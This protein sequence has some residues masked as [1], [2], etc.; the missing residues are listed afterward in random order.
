[1]ED[2]ENMPAAYRQLIYGNHKTDAAGNLLY[3]DAE[4]HE[5]TD[6]GTEDAPHD[7]VYDGAGN[8]ELMQ[9]YSN[10]LTEL[11]G[12]NLWS[13]LNWFSSLSHG[14]GLFSIQKV[15]ISGIVWQDDNANGIQEAGES[16]RFAKVPV[17]LKRYW[18]GTNEEGEGWHLDETFDAHTVTDGNGYWIFDNLQVAGKRVVNGVEETVLYGFQ[19]EIDKLPSGYTITYLNE[20]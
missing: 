17:T 9:V 5:T 3:L 6:A 19:A 2:L 14:Y 7:P 20:A 8:E 12:D 13:D 16:K 10:R 1:M 4:G 18:Y 11:L 15:H